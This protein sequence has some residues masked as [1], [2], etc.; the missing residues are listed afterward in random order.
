MATKYYFTETTTE[1]RRTSEFKKK[2]HQN[3]S[4]KNEKLTSTASISTQFGSHPVAHG[5]PARQ[6]ASQEAYGYH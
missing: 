6:A 4:T 1:E 2:N 5:V 3:L